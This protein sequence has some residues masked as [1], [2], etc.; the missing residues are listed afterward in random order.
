MTEQ[1]LHP[2]PQAPRASIGISSEDRADAVTG[3]LMKQADEPARR[4]ARAIG[5]HGA[6]GAALGPRA[7]FV[8]A[9]CVVRSPVAQPVPAG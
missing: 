8:T 2:P 1:P 4:T 3:I 7:T 5:A 6:G 9:A